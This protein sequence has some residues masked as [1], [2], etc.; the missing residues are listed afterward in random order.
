MKKLLAVLLFAVAM[1]VPRGAFAWSWTEPPTGSSNEI[2]L[3][4]VDAAIAECGTSESEDCW[5]NLASRCILP[6]TLIDAEVF[7]PGGDLDAPTPPRPCQ[8]QC[9]NQ[10][11]TRFNFCRSRV[12]NL[13][14]RCRHQCGLELPRCHGNA[15]Y[16]FSHYE[17]C[18]ACSIHVNVGYDCEYAVDLTFDPQSGTVAECYGEATEVEWQCL[19]VC[20]FHTQ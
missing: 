18:D 4:K 14:N 20:S 17:I 10:S 5:D 13:V 7:E 19:L 16:Y 8:T 9:R 1:V 6:P 2:C 15:D 11:I 3:D 12:V